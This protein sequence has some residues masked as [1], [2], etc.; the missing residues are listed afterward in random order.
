LAEP[1]GSPRPIHGTT[2]TVGIIGWPVERSRSPM[3]HNAAFAALGLDWVNVPMPVAP[4]KLRAAVE[5]LRALG[6][7]GANVTMPHKTLAAAL[8]DDLSEDARRLEAVNTIVVDADGL[9]GHNTDA[10]G[11]ERFLAQGLGVDGS[12][13]RAL[14]YGAGGAARATAL[15]LARSGA[16]RVTLAARDAARGGA[17]GSVLEGL[18]I[19]VE[20]VPFDEAATVRAELIV[21]ATPLGAGGERLPLPE[22]R[23]GMLVVDLLYPDVTPMQ[24][25]A[26][27]AGARAFGG[28][29]LLV[30]QAALSFELWTGRPA[31]IDA[32]SAAAELDPTR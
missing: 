1:P 3:I 10:P 11:F 2:R 18:D 24:D 12:G 14:V 7:A 17:V 20:V 23:P 5:G 13:L 8:M 28:L 6:F 21:N 27:A 32:M 22:L 30:R 19:P 31:P 29:G 16:A 26:E 4:G 9:H 15:A 25:D